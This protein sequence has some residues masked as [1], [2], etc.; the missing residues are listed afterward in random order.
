MTTRTSPS[1]CAR[2]WRRRS[3]PRRCER[4]PLGVGADRR[5]AGRPDRRP[6]SIARPDDA[7]RPH[8]PD[9][10][11]GPPADAG[12]PGDQVPA[13]GRRR[14]QFRRPQLRQ[15]GRGQGRAVQP[16]ARSSGVPGRSPGRDAGRLVEA[17]PSG[18]G[19][20]V[21]SRRARSRA[22]AY[23]DGPLA[24]GQREARGPR[25]RRGAGATAGRR[26]GQPRLSRRLGQPRPAAGDA[27]RKRQAAPG[28]GVRL[29]RRRALDEGPPRAARSRLAGPGP[30]PGLGLCDPRPDQRPARQRR[31]PEPGRHRP[32]QPRPSARPRRLGRAAGLGLGRQ[33]GAGLPGRPTRP[34][35]T[36]A[37]RS[38][39]CRA[40]ARRPW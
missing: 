39:A 1:R 27:G 19:R 7:C 37:W 17:P 3:G 21:L 2:R 28:P 35:T 9:R 18:A 24:R 6:G 14:L 12:P 20:A 31:G 15:P 13:A 23:A 25:R 36:A 4:E 16:A 29:S 8:G 33:P 10:R 32:G 34:S 22:Q 30:G 38:R 26:P 5:G 11:A 40:T